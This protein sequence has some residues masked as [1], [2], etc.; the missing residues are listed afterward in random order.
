[1]SENKE[2]SIVLIKQHD[3]EIGG[4]PH[5]LCFDMVAFAALEDAGYKYTDI[6]DMATKVT[7][8]G[9]PILLWAGIYY[10]ESGL[11]IKDISKTIDLNGFIKLQRVVSKAVLNTVPVAEDEDDAKTKKPDPQETSKKV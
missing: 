5:K 9:I 3:V 8:K 11:T 10:E 1:M 6:I 4:Q 2:A 7:F